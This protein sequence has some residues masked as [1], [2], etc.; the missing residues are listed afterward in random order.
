M[1]AQGEQLADA[2]GIGGRG[3]GRCGAGVFHRVERHVQGDGR[4]I[5]DGAFC[6]GVCRN[7]ETP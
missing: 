2:V 7:T 1:T 5:D 6:Y 4:A 3:N